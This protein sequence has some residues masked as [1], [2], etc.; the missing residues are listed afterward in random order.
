MLIPNLL[1]TKN[2]PQ[3]IDARL[4]CQLA[5]S[6]A[7]AFLLYMPQRM[8]VGASHGIGH[9]LGPM[10]MGHG[11]TSC[12]LLPAVLKY[13]ASVNRREQD[14]VKEII[15]SS[16]DEAKQ[17][18]TEAGLDQTASASEMLDVIFRKLA[19][20]RTLKEMGVEGKEKI[21]IIARNSIKDACTLAN[22]RPMDREELVMEV[23]EMV[24]E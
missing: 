18:L 10:G 17:V 5:A 19:M 15:W 14:R 8:L 13:N 6:I 9:Q 23:L 20:P 24:K 4:Q 12:I 2:N 11:E 1:R 21:E 7:T 22:P 16:S 3:D